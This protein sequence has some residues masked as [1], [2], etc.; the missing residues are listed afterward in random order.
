[1]RPGDMV[2]TP[3]VQWH[4]HGHEGEEPVA[5]WLDVLDIPYIRNLGTVFFDLYP[6][7]RYAESAAHRL[8]KIALWRWAETD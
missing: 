7:E 2:L 1:M 8:V 6:E 4:D 3:S 5:L